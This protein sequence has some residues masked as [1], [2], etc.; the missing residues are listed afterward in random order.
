MR[1]RIWTAALLALA[2]LQWGCG[3]RLVVPREFQSKKVRED[4]PLG[5]QAKPEP[6][7]SGVKTP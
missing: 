4:P 1:K 5:R 3:L 7:L 6:P 2:A